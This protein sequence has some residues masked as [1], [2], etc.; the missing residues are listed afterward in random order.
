MKNKYRKLIFAV[1]SVAIVGLGTAFLVTT[2]S[3]SE[4]Q[5]PR[6]NKGNN[7][8]DRFDKN[9][10]TVDFDPA[11]PLRPE[12]SEVRKNRGDKHKENNQ[13]NEEEEWTLTT[14]RSNARP[15]RAFPIEQSDLIAVGTV[16]DARAFISTDKTAI[17][18][19]FDVNVNDVFLSSKKSILPGSDIVIER[20]GGNVRFPSGKIITRGIGYQ[21]LPRKDKTYV[22]F[23]KWDEAGQDYLIVTGYEIVAD[24]IQPLDGGP[25]R[26]FEEYN[27]YKLVPKYEFFKQ[28]KAA[29]ANASG[30][31]KQ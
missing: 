11:N 18:S 16:N 13:I 7:R 3:Q 29:I 30:G 12:E 2:R 17:Y 1:V 14:I 10:P 15:P 31:G 5:N 25:D 8:T 4:V 24:T 20:M 28:L 19:E 27:R 23:V 22:L 26:F 21:P 6:V 9:N